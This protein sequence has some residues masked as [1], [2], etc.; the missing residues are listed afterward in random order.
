V[1]TTDLGEL[2]RGAT[3]GV[4]PSAGFTEQVLQGG[5]RRRFRRRV[6]MVASTV[7]VA[8]IAVASTTVSW[9]DAAPRA[10]WPGTRPSW[11]R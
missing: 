6:A 2:L 3:A 9:N 1:N 7:V 5:R 4:E 8:A 11:T 10:T